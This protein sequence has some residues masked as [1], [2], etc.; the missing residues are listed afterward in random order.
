[1]KTLQ[2][3]EASSLKAA[4]VRARENGQ[5]YLQDTLLR[6]Y[7]ADLQSK[8]SAL[9]DA[10]AEIQDK[11]HMLAVLTNLDPMFRKL[12][13][14]TAARAL[15]ENFT[16]SMTEEA[17]RIMAAM[18]TKTEVSTDFKASPRDGTVVAVHCV[19]TK[20]ILWKYSQPFGRSFCI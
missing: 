18:M 6:R 7:K 8:N 15:S 19:E 14:K 9:R 12:S 1:M 20:P 3:H 4:R 5:P 16:K 13:L 17:R 2:Q 11:K 10:R